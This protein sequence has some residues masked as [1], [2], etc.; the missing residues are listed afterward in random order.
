MFTLREVTEEKEE[1]KT[2]QVTVQ[3]HR[4]D[5]VYLEG[6]CQGQVNLYI[7][8]AYE[9]RSRYDELSDIK[10]TDTGGIFDI[11]SVTMIRHHLAA[12]GGP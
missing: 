1:D 3:A 6:A 11:M 7:Q 12:V 8:D 10:Y 4:D 9:D 2:I 5:Q